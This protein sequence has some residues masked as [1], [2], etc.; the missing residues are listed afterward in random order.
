MKK[1]IYL[2]LVVIVSTVCAL[3]SCSNDDPK[4]NTIFPTTPIKRD[5]FD[6]WILKNY[7]YPYNINLIYKLKDTETD[8]TYTLS[9]ADSAKSAQLAIMVKYLWFDAYNEVSGADF[10]KANAPRVILMVGSSAY[11][12]QQTEVVGTAEGGYKVSLYKVNA[13]NETLLKDYSTLRT[14]Y[15]HTMHHEFT[16]ILNQVKPYDVAFDKITESAY[17]SGNWYSQ[18]TRDA[19]R[20]GFVSTYAMDQGRED[21]AEMLSYYITLS[22]AE[23]NAII[24]DAG[25]SGAALINQKLEMVRSYMQDSWGIDIDLLRNT[26]LRRAGQIDKLNLNTL[27]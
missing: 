3:S 2:F 22:E 19:H 6:N 27:Q 26:I 24:T 1:Y 14:Y 12:R 16:H 11:T 5:A 18:K 15:F 7:T 9:P 8:L 21:F 4:G 20:A 17:V 10:I 13:L 23:W 25:T